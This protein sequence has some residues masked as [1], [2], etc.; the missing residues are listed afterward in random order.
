MDATAI[1][2]IIAQSCAQATAELVGTQHTRAIVMPADFKLADTE[3]FDNS[4][5]HFRGAYKTTIIGEFIDYVDKHS[6]GN[7]TAVFV[8]AESMK[9]KAIIDMGNHE[10]PMW[11]KHTAGIQLKKQPAYDALLNQNERALTQQD[12]IDFFEDWADSVEFLDKGGNPIDTRFAINLLRRVKASASLSVEQE[13]ANFSASRS[14]LEQ[15]EIKAGAQELPAAFHF[16]CHPYE[17]FSSRMFFCQLRASGTEK[18]Q[19]KYRI[20]GLPAELNQI[21]EEFRDTVQTNLDQI[22][23]YIGEMTYQA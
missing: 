8:D 17:G 14:T 15:V 20:N 23:V 6:L 22:P 9:A 10:A 12:M 21:A 3:A 11:G 2:E 5:A 19:F 18:L 16:D 13:Q 4:P 1:K 7:D